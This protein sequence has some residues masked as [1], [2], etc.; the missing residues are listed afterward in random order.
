MFAYSYHT[1]CDR[2]GFILGTIVT[3]ANV[4]DS[5]VFHEL[6]DQLKE[7]VMK[8][9]VVAVDAGYEFVRHT[10]INKEIYAKR[11]ETIEHFFADLKQKHGLRW[12]NQKGLG[13]ISVTRCLFLLT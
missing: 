13:K 3:P 5:Q 1:A 8:P 6:F 2:N 11:L 10:D 12:T 4:L 9:Q 7:N